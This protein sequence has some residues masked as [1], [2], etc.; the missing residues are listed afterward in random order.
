MSRTALCAPAMKRSRYAPGAGLGTSVRTR[1]W[2]GFPCSVAATSKPPRGWVVTA[3]PTASV[4]CAVPASV[5]CTPTAQAATPG[6]AHVRDARAAV[7]NTSTP[8]RAPAWPRTRTAPLALDQIS[9]P[10][11]NAGEVAVVLTA[12]AWRATARPMVIA[13]SAYLT[14]SS[15]SPA[16]VH[17]RC[18]RAAHAS[19]MPL[20]SAT[21]VRGRCAANP[22][23]SVPAAQTPAAIA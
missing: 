6:T 12:T 7:P 23:P 15:M 17:R 2:R 13:P 11:P 14:T 18:T 5:A 3:T 22:M 4:D 16:S 1:L 10:Q 8:I 20:A 21:F 19:Q 9:A